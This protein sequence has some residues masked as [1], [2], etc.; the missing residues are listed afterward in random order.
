MSDQEVDDIFGEYEKTSYSAEENDSNS[1]NGE[2]DADK[3]KRDKKSETTKTRKLVRSQ[4]LKLDPNRVCGPRGITAVIQNFKNVKL[5]GKGHEKS[6]L[7]TVLSQMEHWAHRLFPKLPFDDCIESVAKLGNNKS[8]QVYMKRFR[9]GMLDTEQEI[10]ETLENTDAQFDNITERGTDV[11]STVMSRPS[12]SLTHISE[13]QQSRMAENK[14]KAE[15]KR[16]SRLML[17]TSNLNDTC[18]NESFT[19]KIL[20]E[21]NATVDT[22]ISETTA[23]TNENNSEIL[24]IDMFLENL[25]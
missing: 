5:Q 9:M 4:Q 2:V 25:P 17:N 23:E 19:S 15:E 24:D 16:K 13:D 1:K 20:P 10:E 8:V 7:E 14:R 21:L 22:V 3:G 11:F 12:Q 18:S 6:D